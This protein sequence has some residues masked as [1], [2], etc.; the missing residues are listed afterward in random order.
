MQNTSNTNKF[1]RIPKINTTEHTNIVI[2]SIIFS[3]SLGVSLDVVVFVVFG[4]IVVFISTIPNIIEI[5]K[6]DDSYLTSLVS[7]LK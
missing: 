6:T 2:I 1:P 3:D 7:L 5:S 4:N